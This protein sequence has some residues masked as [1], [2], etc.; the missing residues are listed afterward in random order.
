M[1]TQ[2][3]TWVEIVLGQVS[4]VERRLGILGSTSSTNGS[5]HENIVND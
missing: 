1:V 2:A 5:L 3:L 4:A